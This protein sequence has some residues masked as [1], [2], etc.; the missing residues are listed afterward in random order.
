MFDTRPVTLTDAQWALVLAPA[1]WGPGFTIQEFEDV[2]AVLI[3]AHNVLRH[4]LPEED[5]RRIDAITDMAL[6]HVADSRNEDFLLAV[7]LTPGVTLQSDLI[8][9][10]DIKETVKDLPREEAMRAV[11]TRL[12]NQRNEICEAFATA[13]LE[14]D[15]LVGYAE[16][17]GLHA[18]DLFATV[19]DTASAHAADLNNDGL[20]T[21]LRYLAEQNGPRGTRDLIDELAASL[22]VH[23]G[24]LTTDR[25][26]TSR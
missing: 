1:A 5:E 13:A 19:H 6:W 8:D 21:Q 14:F 15:G 17:R 10:V 18:G 11:L 9:M 2:H 26:D 22:R 3:R 24:W 20:A 12:I 23:A 16:H 25:K 4:D 7:A